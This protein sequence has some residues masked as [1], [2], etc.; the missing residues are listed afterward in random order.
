MTIEHH[1]ARPST[2][3]LEPEPRHANVARHA[4]IVARQITVAAQAI[5]DATQAVV[6]LLGAIVEYGATSPLLADPLKR[7]AMRVARLLG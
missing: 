3:T 7:L 5:A 1:R 6:W 2:P 4:A